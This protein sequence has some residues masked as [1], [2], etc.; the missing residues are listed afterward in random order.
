MLK[1][2]YTW[3]LAFLILLVLGGGA[4]LSALAVWEPYS[5]GEWLYPVQAWAARVRLLAISDATQLA[6]HALDQLE[7]RVQDLEYRAGGEFEQVTLEAFE[8]ALNQAITAIQAVPPAN[9]TRL[10]LRL[11]AL[12]ARAHAALQKF[13]NAAV[14]GSAL[15]QQI[16]AKAE[17]LLG[18]GAD[19]S[20]DTVVLASLDTSTIPVDL[21][22]TNATATA[23]PA[24]IAAH[25]VPFPPNATP[26]PH[27]FF[28]LTGEHANLQCA[29]C[30]SN[31]T[32]K[33]TS[34]TCLECHT[35]NKPADHFP[36]GCEACHST[37]GWL[38]AKFDHTGY[39][40][41][42]SCHTKNKPAAHYEGQCSLCHS[43]SSWKG[44][45]FNHTVIGSADC[46][47]CHKAPANHWPGACKNC[48]VDTKNWKNVNF[49]H[50]VIGS[51]DCGACHKAPT[52]HWPAP[53][54]RCHVSTASFKTVKFDHS[55]IGSTDC[56]S[57]HQAPTG[58]YAGACSTCHKDTTNWRNAKFDHS[59]IGSTDCSAC[60]A[61]RAPANHYG[62]ACST[63]HRDTGNW[64]NATFNHSTIGGTDCSACH[65]G[66][67]PANHYGGACNAC[68][69][70]TSNWKNANFNHSSIG[71]TD[72]S[73]CHAPPANHFPAPCANCHQDTGNWKNAN[74]N[75]TF[76]TNHHGANCGSCHANN[77]YSSWTCETCHDPNK[78]NQ[79][80]K[81]VNGYDGNCIKCH[82]D[83]KKP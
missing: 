67:A 54:A 33:G 10:H 1:Q 79:K 38:P 55:V 71:G 37:A 44:A 76:P 11:A 23:T 70:D 45:V 13:N 61:G 72:C 60:H 17:A 40:D 18:L 41:C 82:A 14:V 16:V 30:H 63:C 35:Q 52:N 4:G 66:R 42:V 65:A 20:A 51:T 81:D 53:C 21:P 24:L 36:G 47:T 75:H 83:G 34:R 43:T 8:A 64:K 22:A 7:L 27:D 58:H 69:Q 50:S 74:F 68:H 62:G 6:E 3:L 26:G 78:M 46:A 12:M 5:P 2:R 59:T 56:S 32:Y 39:T 19:S 80:H 49:D 73:A 28:P 29:T 31:G 9:Q 25:P 15:Y 57:C 77:N 48:H